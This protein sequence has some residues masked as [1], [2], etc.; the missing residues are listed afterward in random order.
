MSITWKKLERPKTWKPTEAGEEIA[1]Y[2]MGRTL[3]DGKFGQYTVILV[4]V[5]GSDGTSQAY[6]VTG[7]ALISALDGSQV[8]QGA[9]LRV[10]FEGMKELGDGKN[11]KN[12]DVFVGVSLK[13]ESTERADLIRYCESLGLDPS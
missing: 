13:A 8:Q 11:M 9:M 2:Y 3:K 10:V 6:S 1:G 12:F 7:T 5:P 4:M